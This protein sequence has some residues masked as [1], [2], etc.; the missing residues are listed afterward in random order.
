MGALEIRNKKLRC[1]NC[2][3]IRRLLIVPGYPDPKIEIMCHC[4]RSVEPLLEYC[5][6]LKKV[7]DFKLVCAKCGKEEI[8]HPRFCYECLAVYCSKCCNSH[9]PRKTGDEESFKRSSLTGH[10]TIH[11]EKLDFFCINHQTE[12]FKSYCQQCL[13]NICPLCLRENTHEFH[14]V[15]NFEVININKKEKEVIKK[16]IKKAEK[17]IEKNNKLIKA[18]IKKNKKNVNV[19]D[20]EDEFK[21]ISQENDYILELVKYCYDL[22]EHSKTKNYSIIYNLIKNSK[23]NLKILKL[24]KTHNK[25]EQVTDILKYFKKDVFILFKRSKINIEEFEVDNEGEQ[26]EEDDEKEDEREDDTYYTQASTQNFTKRKLSDPKQEN[27]NYTITNTEPNNNNEVPFSAPLNF[28]QAEEEQTYNEPEPETENPSNEINNNIPHPPK[29]EIK[30]LK[31]P[32]MFNRTEEK[33]PISNNPPPKKLKM[34]LMFEKKEEEKKPEKP[35][36]A[37][38]NLKM[39]SIFEKK[40]EDN[41]PKERAAIIKTGASGGLGDRKD[42]LAQMMANKGNM[43]GK[44]KMA[45]PSDNSQPTEEKIEIV[46]ESNEA[47][48]TEQVL[49]KVAVTTKKKKKPRKAKFAIEG[50][51]NQEKPQSPPPSVPPPSENDNNNIQ[52]N[53]QVQQTNNQDN[54]DNNQKPQ[55][56]N[57]Q[58][59]EVLNL[60]DQIVPQS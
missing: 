14:K 24:E 17:K 52:N 10:K 56:N 5:S 43:P 45:S 34:P 54:Q 1:I 7:T 40:E 12:N 23:F 46:H 51:E 6:E 55:E 41:K 49:N 26:D 32:M 37:K 58:Q 2:L 47:G 27:I 35:L 9:L 59:Q 42:F 21:V 50:E 8:K 36:P 33:K 22:Y 39:P 30:K 60:Q 38:A 31:M 20:I 48:T 53:D 29:K 28:L 15:D 18:F 57:Q 25:E 19:K 16:N 4:N 11:V 44:T 3:D 13:M